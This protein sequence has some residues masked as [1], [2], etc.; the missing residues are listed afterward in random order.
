MTI[1]ISELSEKYKDSFKITASEGWIGIKPV[2]PIYE[3]HPAINH[4]I[5]DLMENQA[6]LEG[7][8]LT[9]RLSLSMQ[10]VVLQIDQG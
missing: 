2:E 7:L 3:E 8:L 10:S 4:I 5:M 9:S 6:K 1:T